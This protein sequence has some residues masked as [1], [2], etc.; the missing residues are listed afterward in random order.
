[1]KVAP[2]LL[3]DFGPVGPALAVAG[4]QDLQSLG[5]ARFSRSIAADHDRQARTRSEGEGLLRPNASEPLNSQGREIGSG[6]L[7]PPRRGRR[8]WCHL[9]TLQQALNGIAPIAC[10]ENKAAPVFLEQSFRC[11]S[12]VDE[13]PKIVVHCALR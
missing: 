9:P 4:E 1:M 13:A 6:L 11:Q 3:P 10:R 5:E 8:R 7:F 12:V 2:S